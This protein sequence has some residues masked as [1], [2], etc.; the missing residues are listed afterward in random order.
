MSVEDVGSA[1]HGVGAEGKE[2]RRGWKE[3]KSE[4]GVCEKG[5]K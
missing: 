4:K 2:G 1:S 5:S 3:K